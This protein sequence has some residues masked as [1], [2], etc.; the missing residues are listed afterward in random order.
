MKSGKYIPDLGD[1]IWAD[2]SPAM[3]HEQ[4]GK[5]PLVVLSDKAYNQKVRMLYC[6]PITKREPKYG[7][8]VIYEGIKIKG[9]ILAAQVKAIDF[10]AREIKFEEK[11][12]EESLSKIQLILKEVLHCP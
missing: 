9:V 11:V 12:D 3:G 8:D 7:T 1:I 6:A 10:Y 2:L 4:R 5:R